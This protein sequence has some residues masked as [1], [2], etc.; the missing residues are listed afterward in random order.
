M[1]SLTYCFTSP[2]VC[3]DRTHSTVWG[4]DPANCYCPHPTVFV[5]RALWTYSPSPHRP[6][7]HPEPQHNAGCRM[8]AFSS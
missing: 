3:Y 5:L 1:K 2:S 6:T 8:S 4:D 7:L